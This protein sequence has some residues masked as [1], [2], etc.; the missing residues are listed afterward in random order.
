MQNVNFAG[1]YRDNDQTSD[2]TGDA[3]A[4]GR[5]TVATPRWWHWGAG[6]CPVIVPDEANE[7]K[8]KEELRRE[9][10][11]AESGKLKAESD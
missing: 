3:A 7:E 8:Q 6:P 1:L 11:K 9:T 10:R 5:A 4:L 2:V